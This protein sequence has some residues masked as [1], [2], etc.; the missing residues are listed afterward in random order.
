M[1]C[2]SLCFL[3]DTQSLDMP[4]GLRER[5]LVSQIILVEFQDGHHSNIVASKF[6]SVSRI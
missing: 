2:R 3:G 5:Y 1:L 6:T 4:F